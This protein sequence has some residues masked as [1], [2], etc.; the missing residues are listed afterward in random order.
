M[1]IVGVHLL[2]G[3][4]A[5][6]AVIGRFC[7]MDRVADFCRLRGIFPTGLFPCDGEDVGEVACIRADLCT[8]K[9]GE[10]ELFLRRV[11]RGNLDAREP[12]LIRQFLRRAQL[13]LV[14]IEI[15]YKSGQQ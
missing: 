6:H 1:L 12:R 2:R 15:L 8:A 10:A 4:V 5:C 3:P 7:L 9:A 11:G 13:E 14:D